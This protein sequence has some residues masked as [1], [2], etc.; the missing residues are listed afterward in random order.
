MVILYYSGFPDLLMVESYIVGESTLPKVMGEIQE[1]AIQ[2]CIYF[3]VEP[4]ENYFFKYIY[5]IYS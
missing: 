5:Y 2:D 1:T 4:I 3:A